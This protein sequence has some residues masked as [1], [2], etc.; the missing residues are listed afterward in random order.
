MIGLKRLVEVGEGRPVI[1]ERRCDA[2]PPIFKDSEARC[3][4]MSRHID[5]NRKGFSKDSER[6]TVEVAE[7]D[8]LPSPGH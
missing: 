5:C 6:S 7:V 8:L 4:D 3:G 1:L 2:T